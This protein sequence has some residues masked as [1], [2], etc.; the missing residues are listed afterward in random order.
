[1]IQNINNKKELYVPDLREAIFLSRD[2]WKCVSKETIHNCWLHVNILADKYDLSV[3][4][5]LNE[6]INDKLYA[7]ISA[8]IAKLNKSS[9]NL[10]QF[11]FKA[12]DY[13]ELHSQVPTGELLTSEDIVENGKIDD[14]VDLL[15]S[16]NIE[17]QI[18][19]TVD[20]LNSVSLLIQYSK[21]NNFDF[22]VLIDFKKQIE[23]V[24]YNRLV[25]KKLCF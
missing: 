17:P 4:T 15:D 20:A 19:E 23:S 6:K 10:D 21:N 11:A 9:C 22:D 8:N 7:E 5:Q 12:K 25:Q 16:N 14:D 2:S 18:I 24:S 1:M 3:S 13:I